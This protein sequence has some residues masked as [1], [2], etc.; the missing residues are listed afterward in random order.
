MKKLWQMIK[1]CPLFTTIIL[2]GIIVS[3]GGYVGAYMGIYKWDVSFH[4]PMAQ[5]VLMG[6]KAATDTDVSEDTK[7]KDSEPTTA[8]VVTEEKTAQRVRKR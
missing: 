3:I 8:D 1:G 5:T 7:N 4:H 6:E 2:S